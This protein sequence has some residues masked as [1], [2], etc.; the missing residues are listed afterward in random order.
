M[1]KSCILIV[2]AAKLGSL[3][4]EAKCCILFV[5]LTGLGSLKKEAK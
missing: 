4:R 5:Y 3:K 2:C 1:V